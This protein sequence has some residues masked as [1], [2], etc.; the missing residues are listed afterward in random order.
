MIY[1]TNFKISEK[2]VYNL[3][4][5]YIHLEKEM[6]EGERNK[7]GWKTGSLVKC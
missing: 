7:K 6:E 2:N 1:T 3:K 4:P 5:Y